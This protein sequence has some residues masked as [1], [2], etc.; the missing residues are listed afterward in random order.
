[1][2]GWNAAYEAAKP[3]W[4]KWVD[5]ADAAKPIRDLAAVQR[6]RALELLDQMIDPAANQ[7]S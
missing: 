7:A 1:M 2:T 6:D 3:I 4:R 5:E